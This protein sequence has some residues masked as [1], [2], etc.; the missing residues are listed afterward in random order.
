MKTKEKYIKNSNKKE[1]TKKRDSNLNDL[2]N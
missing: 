2:L 1:E